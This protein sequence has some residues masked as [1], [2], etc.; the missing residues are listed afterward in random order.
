M[1]DTLKWTLAIALPYRVTNLSSG[2]PAIA[3]TVQRPTSNADLRTTV[4]FLIPQVD[5]CHSL[6]IQGLIS[7]ADLRTTVRS[8]LIAQADGMS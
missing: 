4:E 7:N 5:A 2:L 6:T 8:L 1:F 3:L